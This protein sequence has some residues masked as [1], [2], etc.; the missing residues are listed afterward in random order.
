MRAAI[1]IGAAFLLLPT[2]VSAAEWYRVG[3]TDV[4]VTYVDA[5]SVVRTDGKITA[6]INRIW[7]RPTS[8]GMRQAKA[9]YEITCSS[10]SYV[11]RYMIAYQAD[12]DNDSWTPPYK[13]EYAAP[14]TVM[15]STISFVCGDPSLAT[16]VTDPDA[17]ALRLSSK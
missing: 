4:S 8:E 3:L 5:G 1:W 12:G 2:G 13:V 15:D 14:E 11:A 17:D 10:K 16:R 7:F 9:R 6:W